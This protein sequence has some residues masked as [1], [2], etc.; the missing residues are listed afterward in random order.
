MSVL[1]GIRDFSGVHDSQREGIFQV[2]DSAVSPRVVVSADGRGVVSQ[3]G[4]ACC[5]RSPDRSVAGHC[6][7][8]GG[9]SQHSEFQ[10]DRAGIGL[11]LP[12]G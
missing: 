6:A 8:V 10:V 1:Q 5:A 3:A 11:S 12:D 4:W 7:I 2:N 9:L